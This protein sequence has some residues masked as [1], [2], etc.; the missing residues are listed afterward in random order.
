MDPSFR[1]D[2][3][4]A[5]AAVVQFVVDSPEAFCCTANMH[6]AHISMI[7]TGTGTITSPVW[8]SVRV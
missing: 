3:G 7:G 4:C 5:G 6:I 8:V 1:R 2:D